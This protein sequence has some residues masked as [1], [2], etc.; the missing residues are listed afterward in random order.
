MIVLAL[1]QETFPIRPG[2]QAP[3]V[4]CGQSVYDHEGVRRIE[5]RDPWLDRLEAALQDPR[6]RLVGHRIAF[7]VLA[8]I[9]TRPRLAPLWWAAY[10]ADRATCTY[11]REKL[12]RIAQ[13]SLARHSSNSLLDLVRRYKIQTDLRAEDKDGSEGAWRTRYSEL[14]GI[15]PAAWP[16]DARRYALGDLDV[17]PV[18]QAQE[19]APAPWLADQY[20]QARAALWLA[21]T[22]GWGMR[23]DPR[24]V[25]AFR[26][27]V[28]AEHR[29]VRSAL[30][31]GG[32]ALAPWFEEWNRQ[33]PDAPR[34]MDAS[35]LAIPYGGGLVRPVG[36]K[37]TKAAKARMLAV[38]DAKG[39]PL[40]VT[41]TGKKAIEE[42]ADPIA[43]AREYPSLNADA[44][45]GT[46]DP[47][48]IA[49]ARYTSIG[50][51][52]SRADRL[53]AAADAGLPI[54][55][56]FDALKETGRTS[57]SMGDVEPGRPLLAY[58]DQTQNLHRAPGLRE[59]YTARPGCVILS[60]DWTAAELHTLAQTCADLGLDSNMARILNSGRDVHTW[61][62]CQVNGWDYDWAKS[63]GLDETEKKRV[64]SAR[65]AA[66]PCNFGFPGGLGI[67][68]FRLFA[69]R[70]YQ[71]QFTDEEARDRKGIWLASFPEMVGYFAHI[72]ALIESG[73]PLVHF[74]SWRYRGD[75]RYT[76]AAN[77]YFQGRCADMA[78]DAGWRLAR[79][80][81][82][83]G[84]RFRLWNFAHDEFLLEV[85][86]AEASDI[87]VEV[88]RVME[89]AG[90]VW[91]PAAPVKAEPA[92]CRSWRKGA[93]PVRDASG[94]LIPW[95][96]RPVSE[97]TAA[98]IKKSLASGRSP[99]YTSWDFGFTESRI[100]EVA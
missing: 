38:S 13:G 73:E 1:D 100:L 99:L 59:C 17:L 56:R 62:A 18:Y 67:E 3:R 16:E 66:K 15:D 92:L 68:K 48:L 37:D 33:H 31:H 4:V 77:S 53:A 85:P 60:V 55:P 6:V 40:Q 88:V 14:D 10:E 47:V 84:W 93:E 41:D 78:K 86:E 91:C 44:C 23:V 27:M 65:Q 42:G 2:R 58:G 32:P 79:M 9:A 64:K 90:R 19:T 5:L 43:T 52:R 51:L 20:R 46:G 34:A 39:L 7:D 75:V 96:D 22:S 80:S 57:C 72:S 36:T 25:A 12:I 81:M 95:E 28:E 94:R 11:E 54:Q 63:K 30:T 24:A 71:V 35:W 98:R 76:S 82:I 26:E 87:A 29:I 74:G 70:Q 69:A 49:Y 45:A 97:E 83:E 8:S 61:Y 50:T 21:L 89:E